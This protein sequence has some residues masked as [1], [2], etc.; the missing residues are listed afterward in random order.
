M[1][2]NTLHP[3]CPSAPVLRRNGFELR[4]RQF[5]PTQ[6][7]ATPER[8]IEGSRLLVLFYPGR[9]RSWR[10]QDEAQK[11]ARDLFKRSFF[12]A[13]LRWYG[14]PFRS[15]ALSSELQQLLRD[16]VVVGRVSLYFP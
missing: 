11:A 12:V 9:L 8:R 13:Q 7:T 15:S 1:A 3:E 2:D 10:E 14:I 16:S 4:G 5:G 6:T